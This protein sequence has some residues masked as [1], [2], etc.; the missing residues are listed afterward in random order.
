MAVPRNTDEILPRPP[1]GAFHR[2]IEGDDLHGLREEIVAISRRWSLGAAKAV[3]L[4]AVVNELVTNS[5]RYGGGHGQVWVWRA[6]PS[7][8]VEAQ[9]AGWIDLNAGLEDSRIMELSG[10]GLFVTER[11]CASVVLQSGPSGTT[12]RVSKDTAPTSAH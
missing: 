11:L 8:I 10:R 9:D 4:V 7:V 5:I 1:A 3:D 12:V 6:G 2:T